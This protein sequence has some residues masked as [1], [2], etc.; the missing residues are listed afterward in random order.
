MSL[1]CHSYTTFQP[2]NP[3]YPLTHNHTTHKIFIRSSYLSLKLKQNSVHTLRKIN[4]GSSNDIINK[5]TANN[6]VHNTEACKTSMSDQLE[7]QPLKVRYKE[8]D[9]IRNGRKP[10]SLQQAHESYEQLAIALNSLCNTLAQDQ[11]LL[12]TK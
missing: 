7:L 8:Y 12:I 6:V 1:N 11:F 2:L 5:L 9:D 3:H 4:L 10:E